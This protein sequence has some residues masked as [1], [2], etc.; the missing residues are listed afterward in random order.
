MKR[1]FRQ[2]AAGARITKAGNGARLSMIVVHDDAERKYAYGPAQEQRRGAR[3]LESIRR[4]F[5]AAVS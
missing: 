5:A 1:G 4:V 3:R 2:L